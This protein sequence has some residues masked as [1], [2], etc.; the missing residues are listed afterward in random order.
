M[1][2]DTIIAEKPHNPN[3]TVK[4]EA[5]SQTKESEL[6]KLAN[7]TLSTKTFI[8]SQ[9]LI[10]ILGL[11]YIGSLYYII[12]I[13]DLPVTARSKSPFS[14]LPVTKQLTVLDLELDQ[15]DD[16]I[17]VFDSMVLISGRTFP[18]TEVLVASGEKDLIVTSNEEGSFSTSFELE[19]GVNLIQVAVF[20]QTGDPKIIEK[21][22]FYS[23]EEI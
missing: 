16:E 4:S 18:N 22:I 1:T 17:L 6:L 12:N 20:S 10:L 23:E 11:I 19:E 13:K 7:T 15:P 9:M 2:T 21:T 5:V 8:I 3:E 14:I